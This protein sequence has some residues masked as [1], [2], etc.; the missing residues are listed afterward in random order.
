MT[1]FN[2]YS[3]RSIMKFP[4]EMSRE[5]RKIETFSEIDWTLLIKPKIARN[6]QVKFVNMPLNLIG[7]TEDSVSLLPTTLNWQSL[8]ILTSKK[9]YKNRLY[10]IVIITP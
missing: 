9:I 8:E 2:L 1:M 4:Q 6:T 3:L 10:K 7:T 5:L